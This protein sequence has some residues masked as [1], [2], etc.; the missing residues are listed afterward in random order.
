MKKE[1]FALLD[2]AR[3]NAGFLVSE[4]CDFLCVSKRTWYRWQADGYAPRW[5]EN[6]MRIRSGDLETLGWKGWFL[7]HGVL[8]NSILERKY[9]RWEPGNLM[10]EAF[11]RANGKK[12]SGIFALN[13]SRKIE[14]LDKKRMELN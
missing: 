14:I 1:A 5:A 12:Q 4:A 6:A 9:Y 3:L 11:W 13:E 2:E 7:E 10:E 8:Y